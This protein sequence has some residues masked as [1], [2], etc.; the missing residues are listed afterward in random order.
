MR[1]VI[2]GLG[3]SVISVTLAS[4]V[5]LAGIPASG[6]SRA[7]D[8]LTPVA[9]EVQDSD[10]LTPLAAEAQDSE[11]PNAPQHM[12]DRMHELTGLPRDQ[13]IALRT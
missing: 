7:Y 10:L 6:D 8:L 5:A 11:Q 9:T 12:V 1:K 13:I 2:L 4:G 3:A